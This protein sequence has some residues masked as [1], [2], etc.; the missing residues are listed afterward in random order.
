MGDDDGITLGLG[1]EHKGKAIIVPPQKIT[2]QVVD[3]DQDRYRPNPERWVFDR[4]GDIPAIY[5]PYNNPEN[6]FLGSALERFSLKNWRDAYKFANRIGAVAQ[7]SVGDWGNLTEG[8]Q[9][10]LLRQS[11]KTELLKHYNLGLERFK[12]S[13]NVEIPTLTLEIDREAGEIP[14]LDRNGEIVYVKPLKPRDHG[15]TAP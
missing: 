3:L 6:V 2:A 14:A 11:F 13:K 4:L 15:G 7:F 10:N 12:A 1:L 8:K 9:R 5:Y